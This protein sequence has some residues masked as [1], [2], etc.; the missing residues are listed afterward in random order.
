MKDFSTKSGSLVLVFASVCGSVLIVQRKSFKRELLTDRHTQVINTSSNGS[1]VLSIHAY[2]M[3][4]REEGEEGEENI[5]MEGF[6]AGMD[7][8]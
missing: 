5:N 4:G 1:T 2:L 7:E 6:P 3:A 8:Y